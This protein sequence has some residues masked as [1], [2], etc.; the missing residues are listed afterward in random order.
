MICVI[1]ENSA[2]EMPAHH[3]GLPIGGAVFGYVTESKPSF[4]AF[5]PV[6]MIF[7]K[8]ID[9]DIRPKRDGRVAMVISRHKN[10]AFFFLKVIHQF[11]NAVR[12][13]TSRL[14]V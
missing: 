11:E 6:G 5:W 13:F 3:Y 9:V 2:F 10:I 12:T 14:R 1:T 4:S 7:K 8:C